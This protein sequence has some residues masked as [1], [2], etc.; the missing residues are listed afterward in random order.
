MMPIAVD[1][2]TLVR[3]VGAYRI[4]DRSLRASL[5][6]VQSYTE[7]GEAPP[8]P[9]LAA[10]MRAARRYFETLEREARAHLKDIDR[11][12]DDLFQQ[13]YNL[14]AERGVAQRRLAGAGE[15]LALLERAERAER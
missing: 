6:R 15:T 7:R 4:S 1:L 11:R 9:E 14:Q 13:Q 8:E 5:E 12:L 10:F 2:A 3:H